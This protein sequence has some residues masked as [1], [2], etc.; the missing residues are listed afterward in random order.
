MALELGIERPADTASAGGAGVVDSRLRRLMVRVSLVVGVLQLAVVWYIDMTHDTP[1]TNHLFVFSA[2]VAGAAI[3][4]VLF[5]RYAETEYR[6]EMTHQRNLERVELRRADEYLRLK[7]EE[8]LRTQ[9]AMLMADMQLRELPEQ[10][11][12]STNNFD[13]RFTRDVTDDLDRSRAYLFCGVTAVYVAARIESRSEGSPLPLVEVLMIDPCSEVARK[14][15]VGERQRRDNQSNNSPEQVVQ[16]LLDD[17][18]MALVGLFDV[19]RKTQ[20]IAVTHDPGAVIHRNELFDHAAY[21]AR[22]V[23][24]ETANFP[25]TLRWSVSQPSYRRIAETLNDEMR[26]GRRVVFDAGTDEKVLVAHLETLGLDPGRID[27]MRKQYKEQYIDTVGRL[28][29]TARSFK[30]IG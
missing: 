9:R 24:P 26:R 8:E 21:E 13:H 10:I 22:I 2:G 5:A 3:W 25:R 4:W 16:K 7:L 14:Q 18:F 28:V 12:N 30:E 19:R 11:Y 27:E 23:A 29:E 20:Q 17:I 1:T 15:A 6:R